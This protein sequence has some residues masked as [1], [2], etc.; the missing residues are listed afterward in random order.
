MALNI[1]QADIGYDAIGINDF[2]SKLN[3][4]VIT[5]LTILMQAQVPMLR[6]VVDQVWFGQA[7]NAFKT[8]L[9]NDTE[10]MKKTL[11]EIR[12]ELLG[13]FAQIAQNVDNYDA[14]IADSIKNAD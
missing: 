11:Q 3:L 8:K 9:E 7:A 10:T 12:S 6:L 5:E 2:I 4:E 1:D 13:Q 14:Q